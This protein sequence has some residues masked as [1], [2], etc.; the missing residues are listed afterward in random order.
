MTSI[1]VDDQHYCGGSIV[2]SKYV[3][4]AAHCVFRWNG[5]QTA[6]DASDLQVKYSQILH[7]WEGFKKREGIFPNQW[8]LIP[9]S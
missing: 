3:L 1:L 9:N 8:G 7:S 2:A 4:T 5:G 6:I